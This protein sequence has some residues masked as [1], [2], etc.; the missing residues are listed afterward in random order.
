MKAFIS[1]KEETKKKVKNP[2]H[3]NGLL[4]RSCSVLSATQKSKTSILTGPLVMLQNNNNN[5]S[6]NH[7]HPKKKTKKQNTKQN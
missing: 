3:L 1:T 7:H 5:N 6:N 2:M 4:Q